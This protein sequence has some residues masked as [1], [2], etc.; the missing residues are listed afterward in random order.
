MP[1]DAGAGEAAPPTELT[2]RLLQ[3]GTAPLGVIDVRQPQ[4]HYARTAG[5]IAR[6]FALLD[7]WKT[8]YGSDEGASTPGASLVFAAPGQTPTELS[9]AV[10][11]VAQLV[12]SVKQSVA[13][14]TSTVSPTSSSSPEQFRV[15]RRAIS[16]PPPSENLARSTIISPH[17]RGQTQSIAAAPA[18]TTATVGRV[19]ASPSSFPLLLQRKHSEAPT[20]LAKGRELTEPLVSRATTR[21]PLAKSSLSQLH[22]P[23]S[24]AGGDDSARDITS[25][26]VES[27][28]SFPLV[29]RQAAGSEQPAETVPG[30]VAELRVAVA[31]EFRSAPSGTPQ[32]EM[33]WRKSAEGSSSGGMLADGT[34]GGAGSALPLTIS[35]ARG[36]EP[37]VA[38]QATTA[39]SASSTNTE[40]TAPAATTAMPAGPP[41]DEIDIAHLAE[42]V[43]RRLARQLTV[44]RERRGRSRWR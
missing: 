15:R 28:A 41:A 30:D 32:L 12:R 31:T 40:S 7:H 36:G 34:T 1:I 13:A 19:E 8:R 9:H 5:W 20:G 24:L 37:Q 23:P 42:Q 11:S 2:E 4:Q 25:P 39:E 18:Q 14:Q 16:T 17:Y 35:A 10:P 6:R 21:T 3:R 43:S 27:S 44:E 29:Q 38:R 26:V 33:V 22:E